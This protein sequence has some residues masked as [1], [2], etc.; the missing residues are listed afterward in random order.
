MRGKAGPSRDGHTTQLL[1]GPHDM[2]RGRILRFT[3]PMRDGESH[4]IH[5]IC[6][7][8][9]PC[10]DTQQAEERDRPCIAGHGCPN[11]VFRKPLQ[12]VLEHFPQLPTIGKDCRDFIYE[13]SP[14]VNTEICRSLSWQITVEEVLDHIW[15]EQAAFD[16]YGRERDHPVTI[17]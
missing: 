11:I 16:A 13:I 10:F 8:V 14:T 3:H 2:H 5:L 4:S 17:G 12:A 6:A 9:V 1:S 15:T 7:L